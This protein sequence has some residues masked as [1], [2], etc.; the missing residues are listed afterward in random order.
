MHAPEL[1]WEH[2]KREKRK[3]WLIWTSFSVRLSI[4]WK[5]NK[6]GNKLQK[7]LSLSSKYSTPSRLLLHV[8]NIDNWASCLSAPPTLVIT[9]S[10]LKICMSHSSA[11]V[12]INTCKFISLWET[13]EFKLPPN[14]GARLS[15]AFFRPK[16]PPQIKITFE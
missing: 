12:H 4:R 6:W 15:L 9:G 5:G 2:S 3:S 13:S 1:N 7:I 11:L 14:S 16:P 8:W 10:G